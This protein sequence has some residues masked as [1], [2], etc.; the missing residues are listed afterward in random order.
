MEP[1][2]HCGSPG[3]WAWRARGGKC[4]RKEEPTEFLFLKA[5]IQQQGQVFLSTALRKFHFLAA[6]LLQN[7]FLLPGKSFAGSRG[8]EGGN[9]VTAPEGLDPAPAGEILSLFWN[10]LALIAPEDLQL[11]QTGFSSWLSA[12]AV[13]SQLWPHGSSQVRALP[14]VQTEQQE[15]GQELHSWSLQVPSNSGCSVS[16]RF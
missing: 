16:P 7:V 12:A 5:D 14:N 1:S 10:C 2:Q 9:G 4:P 11:L 3:D 13:G 15:T 8:L 6:D